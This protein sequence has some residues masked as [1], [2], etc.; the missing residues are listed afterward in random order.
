M[1]KPRCIG[2]IP[3]FYGL[4]YLEACIKSMEPWV[5]K[6]MVIYT[7][8]GSQGHRTTI[9][10]PESKEELQAIAMM[11]S[12]KVEWHEGIFPNES[13]HRSWIYGHSEGY[14]LVLTLD[15]DEIIEPNDV[16]AALEYAMNSDAHFIGIDGFINFWRSF[17]HVC[18]DGFRPFRILNLRNQNTKQ[19][20]NCK[21]RIYHFST[22][23]NIDI[24]RFKWNVSGHKHEL[25]HRWIEDIY[26]RWTPENMNEEIWRSCGGL[27]C[28][29][30]NLWNVINF[31]KTTIPDILKA[32]PNYNK[33]VV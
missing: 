28:V 1:D 32:H 7:P 30:L 25:R 4:E 6:I 27:H 29:A 11:A 17:N 15:A 10:C 13:S 19:D 33:D 14:D 2:Y 5:E 12:P 26:L 31:D 18:L 24:V 8:I 20:I 22:C 21:C 16:P 23:Q 3:L 9:P